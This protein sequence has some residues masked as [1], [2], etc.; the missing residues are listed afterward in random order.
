MEYTEYKEIYGV[1]TEIER[2]DA[3]A[4]KGA[5]INA[6]GIKRKLDPDFGKIYHVEF[7]HPAL[8]CRDAYAD[9]EFQTPSGQYGHYKSI[10]DK[11]TVTLADGRVF[12]FNTED[13]NDIKPVT[14]DGQ[15]LKAK[16]EYRIEVLIEG[17]EYAIVDRGN[18]MKEIAVVHW[19]AE[20]KKSWGATTN[21]W[22]YECNGTKSP[23]T[24]AFALH[25]ATDLFMH[26]EQENNFISRSRLEELA[27][28]FKDGLIEDD[29]CTAYEYFTEECD[30]DEQELEYFGITNPNE[31]SEE[32]D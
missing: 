5:V 18:Q 12:D 21:Y 4:L 17:K 32:E 24:K 31:G 10:F 28:L 8:G 25:K 7:S 30:M 23:N 20:D 19:L 22:N 27:T 9:I 2:I 29:A 13:E 14:K 15:E 26:L 6:Q 3:Q 1:P 11:G 16:S